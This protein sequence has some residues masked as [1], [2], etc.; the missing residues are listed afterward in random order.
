MVGTKNPYGRSWKGYSNH[1]SQKNAETKAK[2]LI[3]SG[4]YKSKDI[5]IS[6]TVGTS[7]WSVNVPSK[8]K[9][10]AHNGGF[11]QQIVLFKRVSIYCV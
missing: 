11:V 7:S 6:R 8:V 3:K 4:K 2:E 9:Q 1:R 5:W 10:S